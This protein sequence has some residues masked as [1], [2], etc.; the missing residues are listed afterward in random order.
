MV[1]KIIASLVKAMRDDFP[2]RVIPGV[3]SPIRPRRSG[4][5]VGPIPDSDYALVAVG[6][7]RNVDE[8]I[9]RQLARKVR[10]VLKHCIPRVERTLPEPELHAHWR[11]PRNVYM[12]VVVTC[13]RPAVIVAEARS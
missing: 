2:R 12:Q 1:E 8:A 11:S 6:R 7:V 13:A 10:R 9:G 5:V 3:A 4:F